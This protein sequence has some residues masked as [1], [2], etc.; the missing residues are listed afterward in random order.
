MKKI[1]VGF[2]FL[3]LFVAT[4]SSYCAHAEE[5]EA[6]ILF[7]QGEVKIKGE[8]YTGWV[9]AVKGM[10]LFSGNK[11]KTG[12]DS[13]AELGLGGD[14]ANVIRIQ[15]KTLVE[16]TDLGPVDVN[17]LKGELRAL[18]EKLSKDET[19]EI[20]TPMSVCGVRGTGWDTNTDGE[21]VVVDVY[22]DS[23]YFA[24]VTQ[25]GPMGDPLIKTGKRGILTD[26]L[27]PIKIKDLPFGK[28][29]DWKKWKEGFLQRRGTLPGKLKR[30]EQGQKA[31]QDMIK[32]KR[33]IFEK[34]NQGLIE[35]RLDSIPSS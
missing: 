1:L 18:V 34:K 10:I 7:M 22:E 5:G 28:M 31:L 19:F 26:P 13:W 16:L 14:Y 11:L 17:L 8:G 29:Q 35:K 4:F 3:A 12:Y 30:I 20:R 23:V 21:K 32:G 6:I 24:G 9:D 2:M 33:G 25:R 15:E 27:K